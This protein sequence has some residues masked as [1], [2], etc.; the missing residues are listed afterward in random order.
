YFRCDD[1]ITSIPRLLL[2]LLSDDEALA[3]WVPFRVVEREASS[4]GEGKL[5]VKVISLAGSVGEALT[6][7]AQELDSDIVSVFSNALTQMNE[8]GIVKDGILLIIDE[9]DRIK[10][11]N[12]IAS[13]LKVLAARKVKFAL[14]G[15]ATTVQ[16]LILEHES[17]A[18]Q[19]A[20]GTVA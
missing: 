14:I 17:V 19:L 10:D 16:E 8:A 12:G 11:R 4:G 1:T 2:R 15:V 5:D 18:R 3:A 6:E 20:D 7:R 13:L 9:F